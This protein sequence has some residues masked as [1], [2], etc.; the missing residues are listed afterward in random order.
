MNKCLNHLC[1]HL[2]LKFSLQIQKQIYLNVMYFFPREEG[3]E[4]ERDRQREWERD[5]RDRYTEREK[6]REREKKERERKFY[7]ETERFQDNG[8]E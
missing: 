4:K 1:A 5:K 8:I 7:L 6:A 2:N 3:R